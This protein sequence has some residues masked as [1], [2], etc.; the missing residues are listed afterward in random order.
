M[1]SCQNRGDS[2]ATIRCY[3]IAM[4]TW[5]F[6][7]EPVGS[8]QPEFAT[9]LGRASSSFLGARGQLGKKEVLQVAVAEAV[10]DELATVDGLEPSA[11]F[12]VERM[13]GRART[14]WPFQRRVAPGDG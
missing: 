7:N 11:I 2:V 14:R 8:Q 12:V 4:S 1:L 9:D 3:V 5:N 6:A 10:E 13:Q